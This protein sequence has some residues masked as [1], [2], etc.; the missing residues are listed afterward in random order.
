VL[1]NVWCI[2]ALDYRHLLVLIEAPLW[3]VVY[4]IASSD[5]SVVVAVAEN[6]VAISIVLA[7]LLYDLVTVIVTRCASVYS[8]A[9][10]ILPF[11]AV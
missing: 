11:L 7:I 2:T 3:A 6:V 4:T 1:R 8:V 10:T 9:Y 5:S